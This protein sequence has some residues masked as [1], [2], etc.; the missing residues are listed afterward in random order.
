MSNQ[1]WQSFRE[2]RNRT[3]PSPHGWLSLS[4]L[5]WL[6]EA[7]GPLELVP[8]YWSAD[9]GGAQLSAGPQDGLELVH[10]GQ[11]VNGTINAELEE[12]ESLNWVRYGSILIELA[13]RGGRYAIR[14]RDSQAPRLT[15]FSAVPTFD[16]DPS[17][18]VVGTFKPYPAPQTREISTANPRVPGHTDIVGE[19]SFQ[20]GGQGH[21]LLAERSGGGLLLNFYDSSNG[22][23]TAGWR[24]LSVA[25]PAENS[26][27]E[28][29]SVQLD[30]NYA[31][32]WPSGFSAY[33]TCPQPVPE[34]RLDVPVKAG[35]KTL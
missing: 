11:A 15:G 19:I 20:L 2:E 17:F 34:N 35:E 16:Y 6:P 10:G 12:N 14:T 7:S 4:S 8:G 21:T 24:F 5:Q 33:G 31:L 30:F 23:E 29:G 25:A 27:A 32:N 26:S 18:A 9:D 28:K 3:L 1:S 22:Q 13:K